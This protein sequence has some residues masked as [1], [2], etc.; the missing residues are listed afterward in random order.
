MAYL[1]RQAGEITSD[2]RFPKSRV[3]TEAAGKLD[4]RLTKKTALMLRYVMGGG[5]WNRD[6]LP[7]W[8]SDDAVVSKD[9]NGVI[10]SWNAAAQRIFGFTPE[11]AIGRPITIIVPPELR[12]EESQILTRLRAGE[13][14][15]RCETIWQTA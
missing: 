9:R 10:T 14:V 2:P 8:I 11:E 15:D 1:P 3:E 5:I 7:A 4:H 13:R 6:R 12:A